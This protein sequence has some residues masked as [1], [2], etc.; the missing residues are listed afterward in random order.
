[1]F[2]ATLFTEKKIWNQHKCPYTEYMIF[3]KIYNIDTRKYYS[4]IKW[5]KKFTAFNN[6][7]ELENMM[8]NDI[9]QKVSNSTWVS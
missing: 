1:M 6:M 7:V 8:L 5:K 3:N 9:N 2:I 4:P